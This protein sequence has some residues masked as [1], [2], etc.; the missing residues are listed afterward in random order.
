MMLV[1]LVIVIAAIQAKAPHV[2]KYLVSAFLIFWGLTITQGNMNLKEYRFYEV[3]FVYFG[4]I[5]IFNTFM[6]L[7]E[8]YLIIPHW[9]N[10]LLLT[11]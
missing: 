3:W 4:A 11:V 2:K 10:M 9:F 6:C 7:N 1:V 5:F 8:R